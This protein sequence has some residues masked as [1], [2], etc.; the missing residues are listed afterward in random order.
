MVAFTRNDFKRHDIKFSL[1]IFTHTLSEKLSLALLHLK[2]MAAATRSALNALIRFRP[3]LKSASSIEKKECH[4][5]GSGNKCSDPE[6]ISDQCFPEYG[7]A[8][9]CPPRLNF[10]VHFRQAS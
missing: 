7:Y 6:S 9:N 2:L 8:S 10:L 4:L 1:S 3:L 5:L